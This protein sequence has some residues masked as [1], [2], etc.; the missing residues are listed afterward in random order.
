MLDNAM[1][2]ASDGIEV[3]SQVHDGRVEIHVLDDGP[4]FPRDF[5]TDAWE[6]FSRADPARTDGGAGLGLS[7][8]RTIAEL[9]GGETGAANRPAGGADV[10]IT[11]PRA[12]RG[13]P[14]EP[15]RAGAE[16]G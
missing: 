10:W 8:V 4:G 1:R 15:A 9:H 16:R 13:T 12:I 3:T 5:I 14:R 6:R 7:I 2:H 11:L